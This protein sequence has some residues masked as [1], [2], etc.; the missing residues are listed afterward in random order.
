MFKI[1]PEHTYKWTAVVHKPTSQGFEDVELPVTFKALSISA[2]DETIAGGDADR[3][4]LR[5]AWI[6]ADV[7]D[8]GGNPLPWSLELLERLL[9]IPYVRPAVAE[10]YLRSV[11]GAKEKNSPTSP[12]G[13]RAAAS[14]AQAPATT[15]SK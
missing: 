3:A 12:A 11:Y 8:A 15:T 14:A 9:D 7:A 13:G 10:A 1:D 4:L 5:K 2:I 6:G